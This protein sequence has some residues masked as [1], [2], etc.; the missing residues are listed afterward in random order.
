[1]SA[2]R[3]TPLWALTYRKTAHPRNSEEAQG[4]E[5]TD[6][7]DTLNVYDNTEMRTPI[8]VIEY[9]ENYD[10]TN[11]RRLNGGTDDV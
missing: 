3:R 4:W 1:M 5:Y 8:V 9:K 7:S 6:T 10:Q 2:D 11:Y